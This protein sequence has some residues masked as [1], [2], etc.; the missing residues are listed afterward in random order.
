MDEPEGALSVAVTSKQVSA[1]IFAR[2]Q[3]SLVTALHPHH[4]LSPG[5]KLLHMKNRTIPSLEIYESLK[6]NAMNDGQF[7]YKETH[8]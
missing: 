1:L 2:Q 7:S 8:V 4:V 6:S 5:L 3:L